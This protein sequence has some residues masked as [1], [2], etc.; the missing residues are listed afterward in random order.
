MYDELNESPE[1]RAVPDS[2][3]SLISNL[4]EGIIRLKKYEPDDWKVNAVEITED[5]NINY[6]KSFFE[7]YRNLGVPTTNN[8][9]I[10]RN[11][12]RGEL[13]RDVSVVESDGNAPLDT[14]LS[15]DTEIANF[16]ESVGD[17][18]E[19]NYPIVSLETPQAY[20][21]VV[22]ETERLQGELEE[23]TGGLDNLSRMVEI[24]E[25]ADR[26]TNVSF[27]GDFFDIF[28]A[29]E[30]MPFEG[31]GEYNRL[32]DKIID[33]NMEFSDEELLD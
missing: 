23:I 11:L 8:L 3:R 29:T 21:N 4:A 27:Y 20:F 30:E 28:N 7:N 16:L 5:G 33:S 14:R 12:F 31:L 2:Y 32:M 13:W 18:T 10:L 19:V 6:N 17:K 26:S 25:A 15:S 1:E 24:N 9:D 22:T